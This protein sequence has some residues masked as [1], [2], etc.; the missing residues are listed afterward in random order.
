MLVLSRRPDERIV[1]PNLGITVHILRIAGSV[2]RVGVDAPSDVRVIRHELLDPQTPIVAR[3]P[4]EDGRRKLRHLFQNALNVACVASHLAKRQIASGQSEHAE[5]TL[6]R[7]LQELS[8]MDR[9]NQAMATADGTQPRSDSEP[10][11]RYA[12]L[13]EDNANEC[14]LLAGYLR[15][16]GFDVVTAS[17]GEEAIHRLFKSARRPDAVLLDMQLPRLDGAG[18]VHT[19]RNDPRLC[20]L[21]VF[22]VT[23]TSPADVGVTIGPDGVNR[24]FRKPINP[25]SLVASMEQELAGVAN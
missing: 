13:V 8:A 12:L 19:I 7:A 1:F 21:P 24:W 11:R 9:Q 4:A 6:E 16:S 15:L 20:D 10:A 23:G 17:D 5:Q 3:D 18:T 25:I 2:V 14:E 22:A